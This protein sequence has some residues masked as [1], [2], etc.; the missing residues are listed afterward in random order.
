MLKNYLKIALRT[1]RRN[2][3]YSFINILGL[4]ISIAACLLILQYVGFELSYDTFHANADNLYRLTNDRHQNGQLTQHGVITYPS[5]PKAMK[6]DYP[7]VVNYVRL[8]QN[9]VYLRHGETG[10]DENIVYADS[11]FLSMFSFPLLLGEAKTA[12]AAP[13][14]I[15]LSESSAK[16][17]F[18]D[19]W[20]EQEILDKLISRN[21]RVD[22]AITGVFKDVPANSHMKIDFLVSYKTLAQI[23]PAAEESWTN[24][25][26][27]VYLQLLPGTDPQ[28]LKK[29]FAAFS[30]RYFQGTKVTNSLES[31][32]LQPLQDIHLYSDYEYETWAHGNGV[33]V[34][35]LL[36]VAGFI[37]LIAW[38]NYINLTTARSMERAKEAGVRKVV[39]ARKRQLVEQL[40][41]ESLLFNFLGLAAAVML[42][43]LSR[44][45]IA[46][47]LGI[48]FS[49]AFS[50]NRLSLAFIAIFLLGTLASA[51]YPGFLLSSFETIS[52][53]KGKLTRSARGHLMR[54]GLVVFQFV[55]S[56]VLIAGTYAVYSQIDFMLHQN[57]GMNISQ[58]LVVNGPRLT[59]WDST[60]YD[61]INS[62]KAELL[63][64]PAISH[65]T[66]S[67]RMPGSRTGRIF[68]VQSRHSGSDPA[69]RYTTSEIGVDYQFF[70]TF[71]MPILAGRGF[72]RSDHKFDFRSIK[73]VVINATAAKLLGFNKPE[74]A[75]QQGLRYWGKDDWEIV[76]VAGDHHQ[77]SLHVPVEPI[78]F[79][80]L[81]STG[82]NFFIKVKP[83]N[84]AE[85]IATVKSKYLEF[86][87]GN[88]FNHFFLDDRFNAQYQTD[89]RFGAAFGLFA[90][91]GVL[92]ACL[93][94]FGLSF[95]TTAQRTKE[96]GVRKV[97]GASVGSILSLLSKD[98]S[99]LVLLAALL[100]AP[101]T[102]FAVNRWLA[103]YAYRI[104]VGW[105]MFVIPAI[106]V[107]A[108]ALLTVSY[109]CIRAALA[110]PVEALRYE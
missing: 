18:G 72:E 75:L 48:S 74:E 30:E 11:A 6:A 24:S 45:F 40:A 57:L 50:A 47:K 63:R 39:G 86:Y 17:Y 79:M 80:P 13:N 26:F 90:F 59:Q 96:I 36:M 66:A 67:Q 89:R 88:T 76:G 32:Y 77:Q 110:N 1:L 44:P 104:E 29:K 14:S 33:A 92:L 84:L 4:A 98:Y 95:F 21:N 78:I 46:E 51:L 3:I 7:E 97:L 60:Y 71:E 37:L 101:L 69:Q 53:L 70:E 10:F 54:R 83:Q 28:A 94:L 106:I 102:Y 107:L 55:T 43:E 87:P 12:L 99:K 81:Y 35:T 41:I 9:Q 52:V 93:G 23:W 73:A 34:W 5:V 31:F 49:S 38:V 27:M 20:R 108:I 22:Q 61:N 25:N 100:A 58:T 85:T 2:K 56:F 19:K 109:R 105:P 103:G 68:D 64:Y 15:L 16:K 91:L 8:M 42:I 65:V 62:F 82:N